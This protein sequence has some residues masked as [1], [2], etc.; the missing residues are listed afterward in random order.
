MVPVIFWLSMANFNEAQPDS[1]EI[2]A[3]EFESDFNARENPLFQELELDVATDSAPIDD[4][5]TEFFQETP[6]LDTNL[7]QLRNSV[8]TIFHEEAS[9]EDLKLDTSEVNTGNTMTEVSVSIL[10]EELATTTTP[11]TTQAEKPF[12]TRPTET[13][14]TTS[15]GIL[16]NSSSTTRPPRKFPFKKPGVL[17]SNS[18]HSVSSKAKS[19]KKIFLLDTKPLKTEELFGDNLEEDNINGRPPSFRNSALNKFLAKKKRQRAEST[20]EYDP[21]ANFI[22]KYTV[23]TT[24]AT[25]KPEET[26]EE[27]DYEESEALISAISTEEATPRNTEGGKRFGLI[28][29]RPSLFQLRRNRPAESRAEEP[30]RLPMVTRSSFLRSRFANRFE[31]PSVRSASDGQENIQ[32]NFDVTTRSLRPKVSLKELLRRRAEQ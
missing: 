29:R 27:G 28:G 23:T 10:V 13:T 18:L 24:V 4:G 1:Q 31:R 25:E 26:I 9:N 21:L 7:Q 2:L 22:K 3:A 16:E 8:V 15:K 30:L 12:T 32:G 14:L 20:T 19:P 11:P 17:S 5:F 6:D